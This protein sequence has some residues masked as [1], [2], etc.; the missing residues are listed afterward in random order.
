VSWGWQVSKTTS[1]ADDREAIRT[2]INRSGRHLDNQAYDDFISLFAPDGRYRLEADS[3]EIGQ[4][5]TW[6]ALSRD[7]L[8]ALLAESPQHVHDL[9]ARNHLVT[10]D[11]INFSGET[12]Q[13]FSSFAVFRTDQ[14]GLS[15]VYAV[16]EYQDALTRDQ[17]DDWLIADRLTLVRTRMFRTPTPMPL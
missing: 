6:L 9:A 8:A 12:A 4:R 5:M 2:L 10:V 13:A 7:E 11:E 15:E 14:D 3:Q 1:V 17:G 16:G